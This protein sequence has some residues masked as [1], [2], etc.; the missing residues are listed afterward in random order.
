MIYSIIHSTY[1]PMNL[2]LYKLGL[3]LS[4][5]VVRREN[6]LEPRY[7]TSQIHGWKEV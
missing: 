1:E 4:F 2:G 3:N 6:L 5:S 7:I